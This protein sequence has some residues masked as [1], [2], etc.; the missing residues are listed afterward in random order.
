MALDILSVTYF[1]TSITMPDPQISDMHTV[2]DVSA[3]SGV[4]STYKAANSIPK[5][6]LDGALYK[7]FF[8][9]HIL[10][11]SLVFRHDFIRCIDFTH[12]AASNTE[13][14]DVTN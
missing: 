10:S 12:I 1:L 4:R 9:F 14:D 13:S 8:Y 5:N 7:N 3:S 2:N 11:F 6:L